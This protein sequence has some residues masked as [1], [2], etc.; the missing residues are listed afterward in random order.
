MRWGLV[1]KQF[2]VARTLSLVSLKIPAVNYT[3]SI[4]DGADRA[5]IACALNELAGSPDVD[6]FPSD[7]VL[8]RRE[9][10][11]GDKGINRLPHIGRHLVL[12]R[13]TSTC[14]ES[15]GQNRRR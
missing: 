1:T 5:A 2:G 14:R 9:T 3:L 13:L 11:L 15:G 8:L 12:N 7:C 10:K 4:H 6:R